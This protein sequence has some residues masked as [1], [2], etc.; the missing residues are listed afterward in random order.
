MKPSIYAAGGV[1]S[2]RREFDYF[3]D[4]DAINALDISATDKAVARVLL[5]HRNSKTGRC[6]PAIAVIMQETSLSRRTVFRSLKRLQDAD[7]ISVEP[8]FDR[9]GRQTQS[10]YRIHP[11]KALKSGGVTVTRPGCHGDT[12]STKKK[13]PRKKDTLSRSTP[14]HGAPPNSV[15][16]RSASA[17]SRSWSSSQSSRPARQVFAFDPDDRFMSALIDYAAEVELPAIPYDELREFLRAATRGR[18]GSQ[19]LTDHALGAAVDVLRAIVYIEGLPETE[20]G[21]YRASEI[22]RD[23]LWARIGSRPGEWLNGWGVITKPLA[24]EA[25]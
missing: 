12:P 25:A 16:D 9:I 17:A 11:E 8:R 22:L 6:F 15:S 23:R 19:M 3:S 24:R 1:P 20:A 2:D 21:V 10:D 5:D 7:T 18:I 13:E 14:L 4:R